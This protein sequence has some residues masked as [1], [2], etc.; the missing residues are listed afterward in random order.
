MMVTYYKS[1]DSETMIIQTLIVSEI[2]TIKKKKKQLK[3]ILMVL[4]S[5]IIIS[6]SNALLK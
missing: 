6:E 1:N 4:F 5:F 3:N 2:T